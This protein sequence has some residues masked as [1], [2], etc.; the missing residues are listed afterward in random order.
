MEGE[1]AR[2]LVEDE[3]KGWVNKQVPSVCLTWLPVTAGKT[4]DA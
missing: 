3:D 1:L 2:V 4:L